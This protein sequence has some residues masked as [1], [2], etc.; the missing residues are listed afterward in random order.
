MNVVFV[1]PHFPPQFVHFCQ[2][3]KRQGATVLGLGDVHESMLSRD[4]REAL[5]DYC[6][7]PQLNDEDA[8]I[9]AMGYLVWRHGRIDRIDSHN[10][11]WLGL[12]ASLREAFHIPGPGVAQMREWR[13]KLGMA[14]LFEKAGIPH[15]GGEAVRSLDQV[16][17]FARQHGYPLVLKPDTGVGAVRTFKVEDETQVQALPWASLENYLV[18]PFIEG[19]IVTYDGLVDASGEIVFET[20]H[21]YSSGVMEAVTER[22]EVSYW[23]LREL[24][25]AV[26]DMGRRAI[27]AFGLRERFFHIEFFVRPD[28]S[29]CA[30]EVNV[31]PPG[32]YTTDMMNYSADVDLYD[33]W[34]QMLVGKDMSGFSYTRRYHVAHVSRRRDVDYALS[35]P[36]VFEKLGRRLLFHRQLPA[37]WANAMG[38]EAFLIRS[39]ELTQIRSDL[40]LI[41]L[42]RG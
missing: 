2:A 28:K 36:E 9:R 32:G 21:E 14:R 23:N 37:V 26:K 20:S 1:S 13:S 40:E 6:F 7:V 34:A 35:A 25:A 12:E 4:V 42:R 31:R 5:A 10:E 27:E 24:P 39:E 16:T 19:R 15:P 22:G 11:H 33:A 17:A 18:Q 29:V 41:Q 38:E 30:L 3:L 8:A